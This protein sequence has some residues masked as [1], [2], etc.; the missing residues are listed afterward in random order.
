MIENIKD[1]TMPELASYVCSK[2]EEK[3]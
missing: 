2:L 1:M 3:T